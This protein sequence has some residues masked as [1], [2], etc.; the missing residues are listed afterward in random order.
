MI[1]LV[2]CIYIHI[3]YNFRVRN[4]MFGQ[5]QTNLSGKAVCQ[6]IHPIS[7]LLQGRF[8]SRN[9]IFYNGVCKKFDYESALTYA[10]ILLCSVRFHRISPLIIIWW[11]LYLHWKL[12]KHWSTF[13]WSLPLKQCVKIT[14]NVFS[15][16][17]ALLYF[18]RKKVILC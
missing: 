17:Y 15:W 4:N 7:L 12:Q 1:A 11:K 10:M 2:V 6:M 18:L 13:F 16:V 3:S 5:S 8:C 9:K 14:L